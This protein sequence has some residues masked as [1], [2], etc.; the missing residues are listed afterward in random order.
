MQKNTRVR[1]VYRFMLMAMVIGLWLSGC[2]AAT[3]RMH[4]RFPDYRQTMGTMLVPV[5]EIGIVEKMPDGSRIYEEASSHEARR[6]AQQAIVKQLRNRRFR[7]LPVDADSL[8]EDEMASIRSLFRSVNRSI[9]L[10]TIG[11]Q[12][13]PSQKAAFDYQLGPVT[14]ILKT[15][16]A[17]GLVLA[18]GHQTGSDRPARNWISIAVVEPGGRIIWYGIHGDH[19]RFDLKTAEGVNALVAAAMANFWEQGS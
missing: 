6:I 7:A 13:F 16:L 1:N 4:P 10:H 12:V 3:E 2:S 17:D 9:Q 18:I 11:P 15:R 5:P 19:E 8:P 14:G